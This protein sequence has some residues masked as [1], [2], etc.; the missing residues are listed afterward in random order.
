MA[1]KYPP[2]SETVS[3]ARVGHLCNFWSRRPAES[4]PVNPCARKHRLSLFLSLLLSLF[5]ILSFFFLFSL[6]LI[7]LSF[8][9]FAVVKRARESLVGVGEL[10]ILPLAEKKRERERLSATRVTLKYFFSP[11]FFSFRFFYEENRRDA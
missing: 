10:L 8:L 5:S 6:S 9:I 11:L 4:Y 3:V 7:F 1:G 2:T